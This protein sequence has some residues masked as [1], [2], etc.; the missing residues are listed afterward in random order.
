MPHNF[1]KYHVIINNIALL[2]SV[3]HKKSSS[4]TLHLIN[5]VHS[6]NSQK[7]CDIYKCGY[8]TMMDSCL[9][10]TNKIYPKFRNG[11]MDGWTDTQTGIHTYM[12][13]TREIW[14]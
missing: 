12:G 4:Q 8:I 9:L 7:R 1:S 6:K 2:N 5:Q 10:N 3:L 11:Q 14:Q 13:E